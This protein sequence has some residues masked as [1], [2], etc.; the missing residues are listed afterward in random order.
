MS[1]HVQRASALAW[2]DEDHV[3]ANR[4][5]YREKFAAV[6]PLLEQAFAFA[7]PEGGFYHWLDVGGDDQAFARALYEAEHITVLPGSFLSRQ[8]NGHTPGHGYVRVAWVA[9]LDRC[10]DAARR[11]VGWALEHRA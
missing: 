5:L 3:A 7:Q 8:M 10:V 9:E 4:A 11:M 2:S 1:D 6:T